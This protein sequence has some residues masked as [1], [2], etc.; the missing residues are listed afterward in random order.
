MKIFLDTADLD[1]IKLANSWGIIDGVTTN[2]SLIKSAVEKRKNITIEDYIQEIIQTVNGP[3][4]LEVIALKAHEMLTQAQFLY[5]KFR[6]FGD[7]AIKIPIN[8]S[9]GPSVGNFEGL[10]AIQKLTQIGI[11]VNVTLVMTP[12]Q[13][14]LAAKA[15]ASYVSPFVG[16]IDDFI[17]TNLGL[18][19]GVDY[20]KT[21][22]YD[23]SLISQIVNSKILSQVTADAS[24]CPSLIQTLY[25]ESQIGA[26][27][28]VWSGINLVQKI[29][30][31]YKQYNYSTEVIG[32]SIRNLQQVREL[33]EIGTHIATIPFSVVEAMI[34]HPKTREGILSFTADIV[35]AYERLFD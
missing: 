16:R 35:P 2:P 12:E 13:A 11:P 5:Q 34:Q 27:N 4:S 30:T 3:V 32:A 8:T 21:D 22:Y 1:E 7:I 14:L 31:I 9:T 20:Q 26:D 28:G 10:Q 19:R 18:T 6:S 24:F 33:A 25:Q 29:L 17:R 23:A 15:G